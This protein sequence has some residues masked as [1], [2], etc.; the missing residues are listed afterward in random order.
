MNINIENGIATITM[1]ESEL[2]LRFKDGVF[3]T[4][5]IPIENTSDG[6][7]IFMD[8]SAFLNKINMP[9]HVKGYDYIREAVIMCVEDPTV[10]SRITKVLYP[11]IAKNNNTSPTRVERAIRYAISLVWKPHNVELLNRIC[12]TNCNTEGLPLKNSEFI[13]ILVRHMRL[14]ALKGNRYA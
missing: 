7:D 12:G 10:I 1:P 13:A 4:Q 2:F 9:S 6:S 11:T 5:E 3:V 14:Q 8:T